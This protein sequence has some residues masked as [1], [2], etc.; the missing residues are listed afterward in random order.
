MDGLSWC[1]RRIQKDPDATI[2]EIFNRHQDD[3]AATKFER[4]LDDFRNAITPVKAIYSAETEA[5]IRSVLPGPVN[6]TKDQG[7][8]PQQ[9]SRV[10]VHND[11]GLDFDE[12]VDRNP[13]FDS[14]KQRT[15]YDTTEA[16]EYMLINL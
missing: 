15:I 16:D 13:F 2:K 9:V 8:R 4:R 5:L 10:L 14:A 6:S 1:I 7:Q 12:V 3:G 11:Y